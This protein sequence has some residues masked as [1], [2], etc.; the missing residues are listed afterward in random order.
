MA[1]PQLVFQETLVELSR[2]LSPVPPVPQTDADCTVL[3]QLVTASAAPGHEEE[4]EQS[5]HHKASEVA[6]VCLKLV[7]A[8]RAAVLENGGSLEAESAEAWKVIDVTSSRSCSSPGSD[9]YESSNEGHFDVDNGDGSKGDGNFQ[10]TDLSDS[11]ELDSSGECSLQP[12]SILRDAAAPLLV[13]C[14]AHSQDW[15][16]TSKKSRTITKKLLQTLLDVFNCDK[17]S[18][19]LC[20]PRDEEPK[21]KIF[22][23]ALELL[24]PRLCKDTWESN[25]DAKFIFSWMLHQVPRPWLSEFLC[26]VLPPSLLISDDFRIEN[27]VLGIS[28]LHHIIK[29]VPAAELRQFNQAVVLYHALRNHLCTTD[30]AVIEVGLPCLLDLLPVLQKAP[31]AIG[32]YQKEGDNPAD[33]VMQLVL[34]NMEM[35]HRIDLRR[36]YARYLPTLQDRLQ[37]RVV[38]HMK[39]LLQ[40]IVGYLEIND[41]LEEIS[42]LCI[43]ETLQGTIIYAWPRIPC[44][45]PLLLK[46]LLKL[47]YEITCEPNSLPEPV[48]EALLNGATECLVLLNRCCKGQVKI[49]LKGIPSLCN[50]PRLVNCIKRLQQNT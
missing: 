41:G 42:R 17:V 44:R 12:K 30:A 50:E 25:P 32:E 24:T 43:L 26:R 46:T 21:C 47:I 45:L 38:R 48:T 33:Q 6:Q 23:E 1:E 10:Q 15:P 36:L 7:E 8:A 22:R 35:E 37:F 28:C 49:A 11:S 14:G 40:V 3:L 4:V 20:G 34:T 31:P 9:A 18:D 13:L 27:K 5:V 2:C 39:R 16:W 29:N 19:L